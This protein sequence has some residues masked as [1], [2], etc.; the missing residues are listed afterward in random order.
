ML[1]H[2]TMLT[3]RETAAEL[4]LGST[5]TWQLCA[6]GELPVVR[7]GR[8][9]LVTRTDLDAYISAHREGGYGAAGS[10]QL[11]AAREGRRAVVNRSVRA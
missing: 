10:D 8:R 4:R 9:V 3:L 1:G 5:K 11:P 6:R 7:L 2:M